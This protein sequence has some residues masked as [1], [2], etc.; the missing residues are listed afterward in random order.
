MDEDVYIQ[1]LEHEKPVL[2]QKDRVLAIGSEGE[3]YHM[4]D[5]SFNNRY[6]PRLTEA[7]VKRA[8][9]KLIGFFKRGN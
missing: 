2:V 6:D 3:P 5:T 9:K 7:P 4:S 8:L 1:S